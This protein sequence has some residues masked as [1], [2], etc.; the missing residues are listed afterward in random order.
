MLNHMSQFHTKKASN[1]LPMAH[2]SVPNTIAFTYVM[3]VMVSGIAHM[4]MMRLTVST[5]H[6]KVSFV[7]KIP[8]FLFF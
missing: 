3:C 6:K 7:A 1:R 4:V 8:Q 2:L 5:W